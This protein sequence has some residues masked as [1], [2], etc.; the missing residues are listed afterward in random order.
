MKKNVHGNIKMNKTTLIITGDG[1]NI[2]IED[3]PTTE[4]NNNTPWSNKPLSSH[5]C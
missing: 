5:H 4:G 3:Y 1:E 2:A